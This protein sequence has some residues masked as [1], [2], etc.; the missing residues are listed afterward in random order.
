MAE[1][2]SVSAAAV[3]AVARA[4]SG[5]RVVSA[6]GGAGV[7]GAPAGT[8][9]LAE[10]L[11]AGVP[12]GVDPSESVEHD[13]HDSVNTTL[14]PRRVIMAESVP[15]P[16]DRVHPRCGSFCPATTRPCSQIQ[17]LT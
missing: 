6:A 16:A 8:I 12:V 5:A 13:T 17:P 14:M 3:R 11:V 4:V 10:V 15:C 2:S 7:V 9:A 1:S